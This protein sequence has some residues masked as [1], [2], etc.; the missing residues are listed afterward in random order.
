MTS[1]SLLGVPQ[2]RRVKMRYIEEISIQS[3]LSPVAYYFRA[4]SLYDPNLTGVGHQPMYYD[5][6]T[7]WYSRYVVKNVTAKIRPIQILSAS[8][9]NSYYGLLVNTSSASLASTFTTTA[10]LLESPW[11]RDWAIVGNANVTGGL[12]GMNVHMLSAKLNLT[13]FFGVTNLEDGGD[14]S[15]TTTTNP[16]ELAYIAVFMSPMLSTATVTS[17]F[18]IELE[19]DAVFM[20][21]ILVD[22]S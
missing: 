4:N 6:W 1:N 20:D 21:P 18:I 11:T 5:Q 9:N 2:R 17:S 3:S 12:N 22:G 19:Y 13:Q 14:Y 10:A 7:Q 15:A 16:A 8:V